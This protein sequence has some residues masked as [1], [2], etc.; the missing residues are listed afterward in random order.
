MVGKPLLPLTQ[1]DEYPFASSYE[2]GV[3]LSSNNRGTAWVL[4]LEQRRQGN[5]IAAFA[6][7]YRVLDKDAFWV[8]V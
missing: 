1:C 7:T 8:A 3:T 2:G 5:R 6:G 4:G